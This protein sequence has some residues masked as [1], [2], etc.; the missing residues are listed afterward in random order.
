MIIGLDMSCANYDGL[1]KVKESAAQKS[2]VTVNKLV[3]FSGINRLLMTI[4]DFDESYSDEEVK[5]YTALVCKNMAND[6]VCCE[7]DA[8]DK[9]CEDINDAPLPSTPTLQFIST[10]NSDYKRWKS[11]HQELVDAATNGR[12]VELDCGHYLHQ[13]ESE[14]IAEEM[15][16]FI[17]NLE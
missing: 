15:K 3:K 2:T 4:S 9:A 8:I 14:K 13:F 11:A 1:E 12:L 16:E 6:I 17:G 5:Q 10:R 7:N